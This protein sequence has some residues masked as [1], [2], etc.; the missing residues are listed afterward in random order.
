MTTVTTAV[1]VVL[2]I[3]PMGAAAVMIV[4][5]TVVYGSDDVNEDG[6][7]FGTGGADRAVALTT[8]KRL[9]WSRENPTTSAVK[10]RW[11][12]TSRRKP[13]SGFR[14]VTLEGRRT[15]HSVVDW[16]SISNAV[17]TGA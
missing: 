12:E 16:A 2:V 9:Q 3:A 7:G 13:Q 11:I 10:A 15:R 4:V 6:D 1:V 14:F 5:M 17:K 8:R